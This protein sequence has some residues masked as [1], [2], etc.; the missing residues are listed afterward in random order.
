[1][2]LVRAAAR[3]CCRLGIMTPRLGSCTIGD[4]RGRGAVVVS[5][6]GKKIRLPGRVLY[7]LPVGDF[8]ITVPSG[9]CRSARPRSPVQ[10]VLIKWW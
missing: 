7:V 6:A 10:N 5:H 1:M 3:V 9:S 2:R 8:Q 4:G